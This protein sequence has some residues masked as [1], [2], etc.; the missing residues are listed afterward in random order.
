M[1]RFIG[2]HAAPGA[3]VWIVEPDRGNRPAFNRNMAAQGFS[4]LEERIDQPDAIG[5]EA[6]KGRLM[7]YSRQLP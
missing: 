7:T 3:L 4:W 1:A 2:R 6:Y 5:I